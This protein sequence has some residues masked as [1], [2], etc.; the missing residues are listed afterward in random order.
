MI[1]LLLATLPALARGDTLAEIRAELDALD[2]RVSNLEDHAA[3]TRTLDER[4][5]Q[6][7]LHVAERLDG[8][9]V[10]WRP[11]G[12]LVIRGDDGRVATRIGGR[13]HLEAVSGDPDGDVRDAVGDVEAAVRL[14][15][16]RLDIQTR[17]GDDVEARLH[18]EGRDGPQIVDATMTFRDPFPGVGALVLGR[19]K[20]PVGFEFLMSSNDRSFVGQSLVR[21]LFP[22]RA[23]GA[24]ATGTAFDERGT[25]T[26]ALAR[27]DD[28]DTAAE[29]TG[30]GE[31]IVTARA[32][33]LVV[34]DGGTDPLVHLGLVK[35]VERPDDDRK[36][37]RRRP[38]IPTG[39][40]F[41]DT[42]FVASDRVDLTG[43]ELVARRG[44]WTLVS[45]WYEVTV[46]GL[47]GADDASLIGSTTSIAWL[48]TGE[49]R[50]YSNR[51]GIFRR[52]VPLDP[53]SS[54]GLGAWEFALR[55]SRLDLDD[56][57]I[58]GGTLDDWTVG[59]N[60]HLDEHTRLMFDV[61]DADLE[62]VGGARLAE[63]R[64]QHVF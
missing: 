20:Q 56:G 21:A 31:S 16:V 4:L 14:Q 10:T 3:S 17:Y 29:S 51:R 46:A 39:P 2:A 52:V 60:W 26:V 12:G 15:R 57:P 22:G 48:A 25:W 53:V 61:V 34:G 64:L 1:A 7:R 27:P 55:H 28:A 40:R 6:L 50:P 44:P 18:V 62:D 42:G 58:A 23:I 8:P 33:A 45:E 37:F 5:E 11:T 49:V 54:H 47:D 36:R 63:F 43:V 19:K 32:T 59:V 41:V 24:I 30:D 38:E 13:L 9:D 35:S